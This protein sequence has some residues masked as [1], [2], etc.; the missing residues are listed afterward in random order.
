MLYSLPANFPDKLKQLSKFIDNAKIEPIDIHSPSSWDDNYRMAC[1]EYKNEN[2]E[3]FYN[4]KLFDK[5]VKI[6]SERS[7]KSGFVY[8]VKCFNYAPVTCSSSYK[9]DYNDSYISER[10]YHLDRAIE[11]YVHSVKDILVHSFPDLLEIF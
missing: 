9:S 3:Y 8:Y 6:V 1:H 11:L 5:C 10:F 2:P 7:Q 4:F